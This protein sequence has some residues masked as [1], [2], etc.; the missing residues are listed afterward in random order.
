MRFLRDSLQMTSAGS[1]GG[2]QKLTKAEQGGGCIKKTDDSFYRKHK[3][4][5]NI[6]FSE[7]TFTIHMNLV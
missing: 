6:C 4:I 1:V 5:K 2:K 3:V 7:M